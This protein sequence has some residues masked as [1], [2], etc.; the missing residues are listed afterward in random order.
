MRGWLF[1]VNTGIKAKN[2]S[3]FVKVSSTKNVQFF[4][5]PSPCVDGINVWF[6]IGKNV[7]KSQWRDWRILRL[8][9]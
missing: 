3:F 2:V 9:L 5:S 7:L 1:H 8:N 4:D 6:L